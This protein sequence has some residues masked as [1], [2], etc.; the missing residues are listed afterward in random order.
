MD[1]KSVKEQNGITKEDHQLESIILKD[2][3][4]DLPDE[5]II[6]ILSSLPTIVA[7]QTSVLSKRW[8]RMWTSIPVLN[9]YD[10]RDE[11][12]YSYH[13][14]EKFLKF[15]DECLK[16]PYVDTKMTKFNLMMQLYGDCGRVDDWLRFPV[17]K[18]VQELVLHVRPK[19][20]WMYSLPSAILCSRT[21]THLELNGLKL[22]VPVVSL[23]VLKILY[24]KNVKMNDQALKTLVLGSPLLEN[25]HL[26]DCSGLVNPQVISSSLKYMEYYEYYGA[27]R[28]SCRSIKVEATNSHSFIYKELGGR[29]TIDLVR[30]FAITSLSFSKSFLTDQWLEVLISKLPLLESLNLKSCYGLK[31]IKIR[32]QH[33]KDLVIDRMDLLEALNIDTPS[34]VSFS[35]V[36]NPMIKFSMNSLNL[37]YVDIRIGGRLEKK[38]YDIEWYTNLINFL[39]KLNATKNAH[40]FCYNG[41]V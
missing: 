41:K 5:L 23:P 17:E 35:Y 7:V 3:I 15:V 36:G 21:L 2:R 19:R 37:F 24:L 26:N 10:S 32:N 28:S 4:S 39:S 38:T 33:L 11:K 6:H 9:F 31:H 27:D 13:K 25:L 34:L 12:N 14:K 1:T 29:S 30:C 8:R 22:K 18:N 20:R 16:Q 40:I